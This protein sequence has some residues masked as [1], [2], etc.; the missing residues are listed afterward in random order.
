VQTAPTQSFASHEGAGF[1]T[2]ES[3][4]WNTLIEPVQVRLGRE[5]LERGNVS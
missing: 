1:P 5:W 4:V 3:A 2:T